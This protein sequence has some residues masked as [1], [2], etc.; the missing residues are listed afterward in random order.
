M[1]QADRAPFGATSSSDAI[2]MNSDFRGWLICIPS[3]HRTAAAHRRL[4]PTPP[5]LARSTALV[6]SAGPLR[7]A[8]NANRANFQNRLG[9]GGPLQQFADR[10][11]GGSGQACVCKRRKAER[12]AEQEEVKG[13][14]AKRMV[15]K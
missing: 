11:V 2:L 10:G 6:A 15:G 1:P 12:L 3:I 9:C 14:R 5:L 13:W 8:L 7:P 4:V